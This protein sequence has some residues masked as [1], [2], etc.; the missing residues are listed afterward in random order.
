MKRI[1]LTCALMLCVFTVVSSQDNPKPAN[2]ETVRLEAQPQQ[3]INDAQRQ[4]NEARAALDAASARYDAAQQKVITAIFKSMA[5]AGLKPKEWAIKQDQA[6]IYFEKLNPVET[7][8]ATPP[9]R[10]APPVGPS[11]GA[12]A[13]PSKP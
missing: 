9:G 3:D 12:P 8:T 6:G 13:P 4:A 10:A 7:T 1:F 11:G 2:P 5:D